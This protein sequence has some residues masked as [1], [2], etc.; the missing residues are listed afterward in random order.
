MHFTHFYFKRTL[1]LVCASIRSAKAAS[2]TGPTSG[3]GFRGAGRLCLNHSYNVQIFTGRYLLLKAGV[4][5]KK[6]VHC[7]SKLSPSTEAPLARWHSLLGSGHA[8]AR[9]PG[10]P[11]EGASVVRSGPDVE[12]SEGN[13]IR[14][15][16]GREMPR[17]P[18]PSGRQ[19]PA[20]LA[21]VLGTRRPRVAVFVASSQLTLLPFFPSRAVC[22]SCSIKVR[23][24]WGPSEAPRHLGRPTA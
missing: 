19:G 3:W 12:L 20:G 5:N 13:E 22:T 18:E 23:I 16:D 24:A 2:L 1:L 21:G 4:G 8:P 11:C 17:W 6:N 9:R 14:E 7:C 15:S 10:T